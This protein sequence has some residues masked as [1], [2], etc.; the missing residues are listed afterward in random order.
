M[1]TCNK[2]NDFYYLFNRPFANICLSPI[3]S[4]RNESRA[5]ILFC[6]R[7]GIKTNAK[8]NNP[9][10]ST[11]TLYWTR[12]S[13]SL[14]SLPKL[15]RYFGPMTSFGLL[16]DT[17]ISPVASFQSRFPM[18][19]LKGWPPRLSSIKSSRLSSRE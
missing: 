5:Y 19:K 6:D 1:V 16:P 3:F 15:S 13:F 17:A 12:F 11:R 8:E 18:P 14:N 9:C 10:F 2:I 7:P 4:E